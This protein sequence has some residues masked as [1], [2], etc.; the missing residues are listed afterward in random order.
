MKVPARFVAGFHEVLRG[1]R[2]GPEWFEV[3]F[4]EG[5]RVPRD[6]AR[7]VG[8]EVSQGSAQFCNASSEKP[9]DQDWAEH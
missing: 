1:L 5:F 2:G 9:S 7:A 3:R 4:S 6:S 8:P